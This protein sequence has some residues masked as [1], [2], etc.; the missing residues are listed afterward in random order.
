MAHAGLGQ[1]HFHDRD[2]RAVFGPDIHVYDMERAQ[3]D[4]A[5]VKIFYESRLAKLDLVEKLPTIDS[6]FEEL[7][8][9]EE[10]GAAAKTKSRWAALEKLVGAEPRIKQIAIDLVQHFER[11][12]EAMDGKAMIVCM[13]REICVHMYN[14]IVAIKPE[15]HSDDPSEGAIKVVMTGSSSD[16]PTAHGQAYPPQIQ[17]PTRS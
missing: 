14:A 1:E 6:Q 5:T 7:T 10:E 2:T 9:D 11:R 13:S 15:W 3:E 16:K 8:E 12:Q 4:G 17:V